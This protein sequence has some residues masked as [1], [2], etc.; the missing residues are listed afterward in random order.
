MIRSDFATRLTL[1][2]ALIARGAPAAP[3]HLADQLL[4]A[5][6]DTRVLH[7]RIGLVMPLLEPGRQWRHLC[8]PA[9]STDT[10]AHLLAA[11]LGCSAACCHLRRGGPQPAIARLP[12]HRVDCERC[13]QTLRRPPLDE[14][15]RCDVCGGRETQLFHPFAVRL[16]PTL[17]VGD[18]C[19]DCATVLGIRLSEV[20]S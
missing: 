1:A 6:A 8:D 3:V 9:P 14:D 5:S 20:A 18:A 19:L 4:A 7:D 16:G 15:D 12:L 11:L 17:I 10:R 2:H 13:V